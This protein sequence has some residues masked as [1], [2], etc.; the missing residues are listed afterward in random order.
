LRP[1]SELPG[2]FSMPDVDL[3]S[4][5]SF[6]RVLAAYD[7]PSQTGV[8]ERLFIFALVAAKKPQRVFEIGFRFGGSSFLMMSAL[9]DVG[10]GGRLVALDP[11][12]EPALD[13]SR[14]GDRFE[15]VRGSSPEDV[16][17]A[18]ARLGGPVDLCHVDG[19][20]DYE[21][22]LA[23]LEAVYRHL[24]PDAYLLLHDAYW[25][26]VRRAADQFLRRHPRT[27]VDCGFVV[28]WPNAEGWGGVRMLRRPAEPARRSVFGWQR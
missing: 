5:D 17:G 12:P 11:K 4:L 16:P 22:V 13:F 2:I 24:A 8:F 7:C 15:L 1:L 9:E 27:L 10:E 21:P 26:D 20:H 3:G 6:G 25:P 28:P 18:V 19:N 23:D 14:F